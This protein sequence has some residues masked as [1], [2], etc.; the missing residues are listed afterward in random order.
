[1]S[2]SLPYSPLTSP[3]AS[4]PNVAKVVSITASGT[5]LTQGIERL[6]PLLIIYVE[7]GISKT[8][9]IRRL[10]TKLQGVQTTIAT[11]GQLTLGASSELDEELQKFKV[12]IE[13]LFCR[14][15]QD[16]A[17]YSQKLAQKFSR[18]SWPYDFDE[19]ERLFD[20]MSSHI[21]SLRSNLG[22][23]YLLFVKN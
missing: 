6:L 12:Q 23:S 11:I 17:C 18:P 22:K 7:K 20:T 5:A 4:I 16:Q 15:E 1:M 2:Y 9:K 13:Q 21:W 14:L 3:L 10:A 19:S 8:K